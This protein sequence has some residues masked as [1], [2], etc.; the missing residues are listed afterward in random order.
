MKALDKV[1]KVEP[2]RAARLLREIAYSA[3]FI[4]SHIAHFYALAAPDFVVGPNADP[5]ERNILGVVAKVGLEVGGEVLKHRAYAQ[6]I[7]T[8]IGSKATHP[9]TGLPG[10]MSKGITAEQRDEIAA[11]AKSCVEF[12][13]ASLKIF[14]DVV[15]KNKEYVDLIMSDAYQ[16]NTYSMGLVDENNQM[17][18]YDGKIRVVDQEGKEVYKFDVDNYL[19]YIGEHVEP[20]TYLKIPYLKKVGW[21]GFVD[22]KDSGIFRVAP[23]GRINVTEGMA[24][25]LANEAYEKLVDTFG[26]KPIQATL[27]FHWARLVELMYAAERLVELIEDEEVIS[28]NIRNIPTETPG[29][30]IGVVEAPRGTLIHHYVADENGLT[31]KINLIVGTTNNY[32]A[33]NLSVGKAAKGLI[34]GGKVSQDLLNMV[35]MA[36]RAYDPCFS[37]ATHSLPGKAP[38]EIKIYDSDGNLQESIW[39]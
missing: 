14:E 34:K 36:F 39:Q 9:V 17:N 31:K 11:M 19:D 15:L 16:L 4:H 24:T 25:P 32:G 18:L 37:C 8:M 7:Q 29:E 13:K 21:K 26:G 1:Y 38:F 35:E 5:A 6:K 33:I 2:P 22:G 20:W 3:Q 28:D 23:L 27:A 12:A 30:G 10:G